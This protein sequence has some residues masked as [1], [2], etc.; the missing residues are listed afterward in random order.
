MAEIVLLPSIASR[1]A[2]LIVLC[3][4]KNVICKII[5]GIEILSEPGV[6]DPPDKFQPFLTKL[7][8][9]KIAHI[10]AMNNR[11]RTQRLMS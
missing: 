6:F 1:Y 8:E 2:R 11:V 5:D 9:K 7:V 3:E 10:N 4:S